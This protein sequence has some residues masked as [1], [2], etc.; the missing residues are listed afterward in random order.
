METGPSAFGHKTA[1]S[2]SSGALVI[3]ET[4]SAH[5][6][7]GLQLSLFVGSGHKNFIT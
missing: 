6:T 5:K 1:S 4:H 3:P 7:L 2:V